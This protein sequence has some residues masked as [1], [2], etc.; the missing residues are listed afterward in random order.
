MDSTVFA[1]TAKMYDTPGKQKKYSYNII[2][3]ARS[4]IP[5]QLS[6]TDPETKISKLSWINFFFKNPKQKFLKKNVHQMLPK[7][8]CIP[9]IHQNVSFSD[10]PICPVRYFEIYISKL[11]KGFGHL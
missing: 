5:K 9:Q 4:Q 3:I 6:K 7:F 10:K 11:N 8:H 2:K 1:N